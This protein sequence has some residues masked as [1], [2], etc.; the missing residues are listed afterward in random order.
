MVEGAGERKVQ[1]SLVGRKVVQVESREKKIGYTSQE[2]SRVQFKR[3]IDKINSRLLQII[4][5]KRQAE[6]SL[7]EE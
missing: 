3:R 4:N 7:R 1:R 2:T 6:C 5:L